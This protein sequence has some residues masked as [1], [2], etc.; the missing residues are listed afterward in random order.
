MNPNTPNIWNK[1]PYIRKREV[2]YC[3]ICK[4]EFLDPCYMHYLIKNS[5]ERRIRNG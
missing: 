1:K 4:E 3:K 5:Y 2:Y